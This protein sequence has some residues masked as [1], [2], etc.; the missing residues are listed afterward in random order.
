MAHNLSKQRGGS[1]NLAQGTPGYEGGEGRKVK[2]FNQ[3]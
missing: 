2:R 3:K 1:I